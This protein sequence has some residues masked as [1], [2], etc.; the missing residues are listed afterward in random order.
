LEFGQVQRGL[1]GVRIEDVTASMAEDLN[2]DVVK[3]VHIIEVNKGSAAEDAGILRDDVITAINNHE[4]SNVS[5]MQEWV[6]RNRPGQVVDVALR[7]NNMA[8]RLKVKLK[9]FEGNSD[10][11][12]KEISDELGGALFE[13]ISRN[14]LNGLNLDHGVAIKKIENGAWQKAGVKEGF[15]VTFVDKVPVESIEDLNRILENKQG[16]ILVEGSYRDGKRATFGFD[17]E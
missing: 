5:E 15:I 1:L 14:E 9:D 13:E 7:R 6:A 16:A 10:S 17:W 11:R 2:L 8:K 12:K 3:G 4:V